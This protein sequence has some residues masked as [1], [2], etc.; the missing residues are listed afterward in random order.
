MIYEYILEEISNA[1]ARSYTLRHLPHSRT[2][3]FVA[4]RQRSRPYL[5]LTQVCRLLRLEFKPLYIWSKPTVPF[6]DTPAY[7]EQYPLPDAEKSQEIAKILRDLGQPVKMDD[8][9]LIDILPL[10]R[11]GIEDL[12]FLLFSPSDIS[13][14]R[15]HNRAPIVDFVVEWAY[16]AARR[17]QDCDCTN[18]VV[19]IGMRQHKVRWK[20]KTLKMEVDI[21][22]SLDQEAMEKLD[23][24][25]TLAVMRK[26]GHHCP[27]YYWREAYTQFRMGPWTFDRWKEKWRVTNDKG[28]YGY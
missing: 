8:P 1:P 20:Y 5:G 13:H 19:K 15:S 2:T 9:T 4:E 26:L 7:L 16:L 24:D 10:L 28:A 12:P 14:T 21:V 22:F 11:Y 23:E 27:A 25:E 6:L 3:R 18:K 17:C